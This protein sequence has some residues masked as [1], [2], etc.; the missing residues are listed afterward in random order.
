[1]EVISHVLVAAPINEN[2]LKSAA[3]F[4]REAC[5]SNFQLMTA[6][7]PHL[8]GFDGSLQRKTV[9]YSKG[10]SFRDPMP[11]AE[12]VAHNGEKPR[13]LPI[14]WVHA[15]RRRFTKVSR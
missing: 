9:R 13:F 10:L 12:T 6:N 3:I 7:S 4:G 14:A 1:M 11:C 15:N 2:E 5:A 8:F